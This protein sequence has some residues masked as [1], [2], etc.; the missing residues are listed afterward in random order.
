MKLKK[1]II[2]QLAQLNSQKFEFKEEIKKNRHLTTLKPWTMKMWI[3]Y[4]NFELNSEC[5]EFDVADLLM[6]QCSNVL[7]LGM[8]RV[9][10]QWMVLVRTDCSF[11]LLWVKCVITNMIMMIYFNGSLGRHVVSDVSRIPSWFIFVF[12]FKFQEAHEK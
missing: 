12:F 10:G 1:V 4:L 2:L 7:Q 5:W 9:V 8:F 6:S 11:D 3:P